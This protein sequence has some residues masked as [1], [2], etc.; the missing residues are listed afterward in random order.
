MEKREEEEGE[1]TRH[2]QGLFSPLPS[3]VPVVFCLSHGEEEECRG[4]NG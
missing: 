3:F 4:M 2:D 1:E